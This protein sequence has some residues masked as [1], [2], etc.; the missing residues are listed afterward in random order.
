MRTLE[1][2]S[3]IY[4]I[5]KIAG[6][7]ERDYNFSPPTGYKS[8]LPSGFPVG[9]SHLTTAVFTS[10]LS[11][12]QVPSIFYLRWFSRLTFPVNLRAIILNLDFALMSAASLLQSWLRTCVC[13]RAAFSSWEDQADPRKG[14]TYLTNS[15]LLLSLTIHHQPERQLRCNTSTHPLKKHHVK[16]P[17]T[18]SKVAQKLYCNLIVCWLIT[19]GT[20]AGHH[21]IAK[22][23]WKSLL[24]GMT[25]IV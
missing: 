3:Y 7:I 1:P 11:A 21:A 20:M 5:S 6:S 23:S 24:L 16:W 17:F 12:P 22:W 15:A 10:M 2:G 13:Q 9:N 4:Q 14:P 18:R 25:W 19:N 8:L